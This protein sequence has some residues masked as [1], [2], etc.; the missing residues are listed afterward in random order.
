M[1]HGKF[2]FRLRLI[3]LSTVRLDMSFLSAVPSFQCQALCHS[4][5]CL[6]RYRID[7]SSSSLSLADKYV[8]AGLDVFKDNN[9]FYVLWG[10]FM[11]MLEDPSLKRVLVVDALD[12][13]IDKDTPGLARPV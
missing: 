6:L 9:A 10:A 3:R 2:R 12:E 4:H 1:I 8:A 5:S 11:S 7:F 13:G